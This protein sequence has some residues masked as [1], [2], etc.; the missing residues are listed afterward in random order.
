MRNL[1]LLS[2][3]LLTGSV[4]HA[5]YNV[6][7]ELTSS[8]PVNTGDTLYLAGSF[9]GWNP[10]D[11]KYGF[12]PGKTL[13]ISLPAG[14]FEYKITRGSWERSECKADG[15][16]VPNRQLILQSDTVLRLRVEEWSDRVAPK[17]KQSTASRQVQ[18]LDTAFYIPKLNRTRRVWIYLPEDYTTDLS[19]HYPVLY[20]HDG[21]NLFE[22]TTSYSG[23]W[24]VDEYLDSI[25]M[26]KCIVVGIDHGGEKRMN[27]YSPFNHEEFGKGEGAAYVDF[28]AKKLKPFIDKKFRTIRNRQHTFIAGSSMGG[29]ISMFAV[30]RHPR[31]FGG[32][33]VF[34]PSFWVS[35]EINQYIRKRGKKYKGLVYFYAGK[36]EGEQMVQQLL[37]GF[38]ILS[39][40]SKAKS[41]VV[42]RN[43]GM[44]NETTWRKEFPL[45][46]QWLLQSKK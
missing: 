25:K 42:I 46:Y 9:N 15:S 17:P 33:G 5:Q 7:L 23:E 37:K 3:V 28:V 21:Q 45:F 38:E 44:H 24:G 40:V 11:P 4:A 30:L 18:V 35:D 8:A 16:S 6:R 1:L 12:L 26:K 39:S 13:V 29:L 43:D 10:A 36:Q 31:V 34:S 41:T 32:A 2:F 27:E 20:M 14:G 19:I 22:D